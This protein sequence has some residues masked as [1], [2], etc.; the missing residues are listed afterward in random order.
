MI[1]INK[2]H[3]GKVNKA[4]AWLEKYNALNTLRDIADGD[5][6]DKEFRKLDRKCEAAYDRFLDYMDEM[7][8]REQRAIYSSKLY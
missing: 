7:P 6:N 5:G 3:Q 2:L 8:N 1:A 4:V